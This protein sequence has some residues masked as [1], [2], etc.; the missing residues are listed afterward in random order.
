MSRSIGILV[1]SDRYPDYVIRLTEAADKKAKEVRIFF[2]GSAVKLSL[3]PDVK[4]LADKASLFICYVSF[5]SNGLAGREDEV[6]KGTFGGFTSQAKNAEILAE[7]D[8]YIVL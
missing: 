3:L 6:P 7:C 2:T 5:R 8:R 4:K 1:T